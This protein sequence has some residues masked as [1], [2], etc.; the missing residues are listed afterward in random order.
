[1]LNVEFYKHHPK[2][3]SIKNI[4]IKITLKR[5]KKKIRQN[6][7]K[8]PKNYPLTKVNNNEISI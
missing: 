4:I 8:I 6:T 7:K 2:H 5:K 3:F 1:M